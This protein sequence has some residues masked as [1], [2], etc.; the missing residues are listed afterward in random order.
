[1]QKDVSI[2]KILLS[3]GILPNMKGYVYCFELLKS[4]YYGAVMKDL[5]KKLGAKYSVLPNSIEKSVS[6]SIEK[7][8]LKCDI[9]E[10]YNKY[11]KKSGK[12]SNKKFI[13]MLYSQLC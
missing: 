11:C 9:V 13:K 12:V 10:K 8:F 4:Y 5:Y 2:K 7:A 3:N 1:M 6:N